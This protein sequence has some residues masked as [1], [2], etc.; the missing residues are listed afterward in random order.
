MHMQ[1]S[2]RLPLRSIPVPPGASLGF[3]EER[4][5][6]DF[7]PLPHLPVFYVRIVDKG[8]VFLSERTRRSIAG[9][10]FVV[11]R[12]HES[13]QVILMVISRRA[14]GKNCSAGKLVNGRIKLSLVCHPDGIVP[15]EV[16][17]VARGY[18]N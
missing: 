13:M 15:R 18:S 5:L 6:P 11:G 1:A 3:P 9:R 16:A 17:R 4:F 10:G 7:H 12:G 2:T 8:T 14:S